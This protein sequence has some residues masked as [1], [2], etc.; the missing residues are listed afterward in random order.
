LQVTT[1]NA[2]I[3]LAR[4]EPSQREEVVQR[5]TDAGEPVTAATIKRH[6]RTPSMPPSDTQGTALPSGPPPPAQVLDATDLAI[7]NTVDCARAT[8]GRSAGEEDNTQAMN[9]RQKG[10]RGE[11]DFARLLRLNG[12]D[13]RRGQQFAGGVESPDVVSSALDWLHIE[14]KRAEHLDLTA[15]CAQAARDAGG[16]PWIVAHRRNRGPWFITLDADECYRLLN[17]VAGL[18]DLWPFTSPRPLTMDA[19][20]FFQ[21]LRGTLPRFTE[22]GPV[23]PGELGTQEIRKE[24]PS[25]N[26]ET[27]E[28]EAEAISDGDVCSRPAVA[29]QRQPSNR[30][31]T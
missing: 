29:T 19:E 27:H 1:Q 21:F 13:A 12:F 7:P 25:R 22:R 18:S 3:E 9:S 23:E 10:K 14:V 17:R 11:L 20:L 6:A 30:T 31:E 26:S 2:A 4:V 15:A 8:P 16:K 24:G 5:I 28:G